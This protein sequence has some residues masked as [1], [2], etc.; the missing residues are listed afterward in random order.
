MGAIKSVD[1]MLLDG[2]S[3]SDEDA[4]SSSAAAPGLDAFL[5]AA[6]LAHLSEVLSA[7]TL[8]GL[9]SWLARSR[10]AFLSK[11]KRLG[12]ASTQDRQKLANALTKATRLGELPTPTVSEILAAIDVDDVAPPPRPMAPTVG[13]SSSSAR[14][15]RP[16]DPLVRCL[17]STVE[18]RSTTSAAESIPR[19]IFQTSRTARVGVALWH[20]VR[21]MLE[22]NPTWRYEFFDDARCELLLSQA[23]ASG[24]APPRTLEA[25]RSLRAGAAKADLWR[26]VAVYVHGGLY[27][28]LDATINGV[29]DETLPTVCAGG[30]SCWLYDTSCNLIQWL[31]LC[32]RGDA[33]CRA[34]ID[35]CVA[36]VLARQPNIFLATGPTVLNDAFLRATSGVQVYDSSMGLADEERS[37]LLQRAGAKPEH[38]FPIGFFVNKYPGY[39]TEHIYV[40]RATDEDNFYY[41][42]TWGQP[43]PG[44]Y[45]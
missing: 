2:F 8:R 28:D 4:E 6:G 40:D 43:T 15:R 27:L 38:V 32:A 5:E 35:E 37:A 33:A 1:A 7:E 10:T 19:T 45:H 16:D 11:T 29:L 42:P 24:A 20:Q 44:L 25:F 39:H 9:N 30:G 36:R 12:V 14:A 17:P 23:E 13:S 21:R 34:T 31:L 18:A 41:T 22:A 3:D 26:Y